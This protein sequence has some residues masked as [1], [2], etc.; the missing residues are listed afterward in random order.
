MTGMVRATALEPRR[1]SLVL[2]SG[3]AVGSQVPVDQRAADAEGP[4]DLGGALAARA[5][6][7][8]RGVHH[9]RAAAVAALGA[10]GGEPGH[11]ALVDDAPLEFGERDH[12]RE[13]E[14]ALAG[15]A[16]RRPTVCR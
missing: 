4:G 13:E 8:G 2:L 14:L 1:T 12:H 11:G 3:P 5:S 16:S 7:P 10:R 15:R 9:G 6:C